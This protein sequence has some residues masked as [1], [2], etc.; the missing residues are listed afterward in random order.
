MG[1]TARWRNS[2]E[3]SP[4]APGDRRNGL[5]PPYRVGRNQEK[6]HDGTIVA[7][8]VNEIWGTDMSQPVTLE[9]GRA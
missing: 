4:R 7:G 2:L 9:E 3:P 8:K 5:L 6:M 1:A